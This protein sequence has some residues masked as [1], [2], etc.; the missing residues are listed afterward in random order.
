MTFSIL[1]S[2]TKKNYYLSYYRYY[3]LQIT[4]TFNILFPSDL[5]SYHLKFVLHYILI[6]INN[7]IIRALNIS[8]FKKKINVFFFRF[9]GSL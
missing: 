6:F 9:H 5:P 7:K 1:S 3:S 2:L 4:R 8:F